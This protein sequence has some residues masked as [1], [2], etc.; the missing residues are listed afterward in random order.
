LI[1]AHVF[2][3]SLPIAIF[4]AVCAFAIWKGGEDER[5]VGAALAIAAIATPFLKDHRWLGPQW[6]VFAVD[7]AFFGLMLVIAFRTSKF[8]PLAAAGFQLLGLLT[9]AAMLIDKSVRAWAYV[10]AGVI[11]SY[12]IL[13]ALALGTWNTWRGAR[14]HP[15]ISGAPAAAGETRR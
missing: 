1:T 12:L 8:W 9:H 15:A 14:A 4:V 13:A 10:T 11:W 6:G 7:A 5:L 3:A 2:S